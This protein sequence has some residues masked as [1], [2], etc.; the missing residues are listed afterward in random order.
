MNG[1][2]VRRVVAINSGGYRFADVAMDGPIHLVAPNNR[3]KSTLVNALQF[4]YVDDFR[5]M[6]F[7]RSPDETRDHYFGRTPS[8]LL[9]ECVTA[10]GPQ[11]LLVVGRGR[12]AGATFARYVFAGGYE[13]EDFRDPQGRVAEFDSVKT[14]LADRS[15]AEIKHSELWEVLCNAPRRGRAEENGHRLPQ[16]GLL[17]IRAREDYR[18]FREAYVRLLS[19]SD[20]SA[21]ELRQLLIDCHASEVGDIKLD[22]AA[23]Y[24]DEFERAERT[25]ARLGFLDATGHLI[26]DGERRRARAESYRRQIE[27][28]APTAIAEAS[29]LLAA[30]QQG[31]AAAQQAQATLDDRQRQLNVDREGIT[32]RQGRTQG[33]FERGQKDLAEID[34]LHAKWSA[35]TAEMLQVM[36]DNADAARDGIAAQKERIRQAGSFN[37]DAMRRSVRDLQLDAERH[38]RSLSNWEKQLSGWLAERGMAAERVIDA[39][40]VLNPAL[41]RLLL[42]DEVEIADPPGLLARIESIAQRIDSGRYTDDYIRADLSSVKGPDEAELH[43]AAAAKES[44]RIVKARLQEEL[45]RLHVAENTNRA[46]A[47]LETME[48]EHRELAEKLAEYDT[49][50]RRWQQRPDREREVASLA[51]DLANIDIELEQLRAEERQIAEDRRQ[52]SNEARAWRDAIGRLDASTRKFEAA[53]EVIGLPMPQADAAVASGALPEAQEAANKVAGCTA[54]L[55]GLAT[56]AGEYKSEREKVQVIQRRV[57]G[58]SQEHAQPRYFI[59]DDEADWAEL[60]EARRAMPELHQANQQSWDAL[61]TTIRARLDALMRG[62]R[63]ISA[64]ATRVN[65]AMKRHSV[66]NLREVQ[67]DV[68][69]QHEACDLLESLTGPDGLFADREA[70][71]RA[72]DRLRRWIKDGKIIRLQDLFAIRIRVQGMD[73]EWS[74]AKSLDDI[75]STGT[76]MTAKAMIFIQLVRAVVADERY[77][78]HFYLDETGQLDDKNL[79]AT[80]SMAMERGVVPITA[81]PRV[82]AEPLAH[83]VVTVYSLGQDANGRFFIDARRVFRATRRS[84]KLETADV[85]DR[86]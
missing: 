65:S 33:D 82:R 42:G 29:T 2:G 24:R 67:L 9:F 3:G 76:G 7:P 68:V 77:R 75:G 36:R 85:A 66:S 6:R 34:A 20:M 52:H 15:L 30:L 12:I 60:I 43:D 69:R 72:R 25:E 31:E 86:A 54:S 49:Y 27:A 5:A 40:R 55:D 50:L 39:F 18:S 51:E 13:P 81:E 22:V 80:T 56:I 8:Y 71:D 62:F 83:P 10:T 28:A 19:L 14:R 11:S 32:R 78:L 79:E 59:G 53:I 4:L 64:A 35:C 44:L 74:E 84:A 58:L 16:L 17:P 46:R 73:G 70:L 57:D 26:D 63:A 23:D 41:L 38:E 47:A 45:D 21:A 37:L 61:F 48:R 1:F